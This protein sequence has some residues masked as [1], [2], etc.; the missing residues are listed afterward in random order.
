M[1]SQHTDRLSEGC[2]SWCLN[3][4][5]AVTGTAVRHCS[6]CMSCWCGSGSSMQNA[7]S[8]PSHHI[9][10][11]NQ[12]TASSAGCSI[13]FGLPRRWRCEPRV[14][15]GPGQEFSA[16]F[17]CADL[18]AEWPVHG[19]LRL[20]R[21]ISPLVVAPTVLFEKPI[22][23]TSAFSSWRSGQ[24]AEPAAGGGGDAAVHARPGSHLR[25][26]RHRRRAAHR[27]GGPLVHLQPA[28]GAY[29]PMISM[30][31]AL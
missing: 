23:M 8:L 7:G 25:G 24:P 15:L 11:T 31:P 1:I 20:A 3:T 28:R 14:A 19:G 29:H 6:I 13:P 4:W 18:R 10:Q 9:R 21:P 27:G 12:H 17:I 5:T 2:L 16:A 22:A 30:F 26:N